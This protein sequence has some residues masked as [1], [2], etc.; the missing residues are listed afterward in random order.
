MARTYLSKRLDPLIR[1]FPALRAFAWTLE[2]VILGV[3]WLISYCLTPAAASRFGSFIMRSIGPLI[4]KHRDLLANL[5]IMFP[6]RDEKDITMLAR[7]VWGNLGSVMAEY[8]HLRHIAKSRVEIRMTD[9]ARRIVESREPTIYMAAHLA[10]WELVPACV[11]NLGIPLSVVY[12]PQ[13]NP[14][15]ERMIQRQRTSTGYEFI[16]K[17]DAFQEI[18][19]TLVQ[20]RSVGLVPDQRADAG[21]L[22]TFFGHVAETTVIPARIAHRVGCPVVPIRV[23]RLRGCWFRITFD[24][25]IDTHPELKGKEASIKST[26]EFLDRLE[27]WISAHPGQWLAIRRRWP[28]VETEVEVSAGT[29]VSVGTEMGVS[30][31]SELGASAVAELGTAPNTD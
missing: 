22:L 11:V 25:P 8:P 19:Q 29:V 1:R 28:K 24:D 27:G 14:L 23:E 15:V 20:H 26:R 12:S 31:V 16:A 4:F 17:A 10:N 2:A 30:A 13:Q 21:E 18:I 3:L 9:A 5:R 6:D 7:E